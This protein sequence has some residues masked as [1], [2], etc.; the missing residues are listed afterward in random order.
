MDLTVAAS[1]V[2]RWARNLA[3]KIQDGGLRARFLLR[4]RDSKF[5]ATFDQVFS[6]EGVKVIHLP[7]RSPLA[8]SIAERL[9]GT[10]RLELLDHL[11][12]FPLSISRL[13]SKSS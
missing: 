1:R 12:I 10:V 8:N 4:D 5:T 3:W 13:S 6:S 9:I 7:F 11:L 2:D